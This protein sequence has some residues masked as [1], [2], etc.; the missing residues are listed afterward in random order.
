MAKNVKSAKA[1]KDAK[2]AKG[3]KKK[4]SKGVRAL[5]LLFGLGFLTILLSFI[6]QK[7]GQEL[8]QS[9]TVPA[10]VDM[11]FGMGGEGP[12]HFK[13][14]LGLAVD[15]AGD[16]YVSDFSG[17]NVQK[18]DR[19]GAPLTTLGKEGKEEGQFEQPSGLYVDAQDNLYVCDTFNHRIQKFDA[20]G[21]FVK[22]FA[23][24]FFGPRSVVGNGLNRIYVSDTGNHKVKVFDLDGNFIKEWGGFGT[25]EG[26]FEEPVGITADDHNNIYVADSDNKRIQKFDPEGKFMGAFK[27]STWKGKN[28][29][30]PYLSFG[31][32][33]LWAS[34]T[35]R[36]A[37]LKLDPATGKLLAICVRK[38]KEG[39]LGAAGVAFAGEGRVLVVEKG[40][41]QVAR[42][43]LPVMPGK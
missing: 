15:K 37:V 38:E 21:K 11:E 6:V 3:P 9:K 19:N 24:G 29:E 20:K 8:D 33:A 14:P 16:F 18:F 2:G 26:K 36:G 42:F 1:S 23:N 43:G 13:E 27:I 10:M 4:M 32:G 25:S 17:H 22:T 40:K 39:F 5:M 31:D 41:D 7:V 12:G 30:V 28:D 34:S 35:S